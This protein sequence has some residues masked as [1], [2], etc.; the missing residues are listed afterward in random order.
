MLKKHTLMGAAIA[1]ALSAGSV[2]AAVSPQE[3]A[4]LGT[5]LTPM[6][7]EKAG[8]A[9][10]TIPAWTGG[11]TTTPWQPIGGALR[12]RGLGGGVRARSA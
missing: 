1:L 9:A 3:A 12:P 5:S 8:N 11:I 6:G 4:K 10:G 2:L 7:G